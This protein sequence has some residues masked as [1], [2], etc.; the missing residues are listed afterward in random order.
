MFLRSTAL[1]RPAKTL[2]SRRLQHRSY[3]KATSTYLFSA[4]APADHAD[5]PKAPSSP[6]SG[7]GLAAATSY[8]G[9]AAAGG[10][11]SLLSV[12]ISGI[13]MS[14]L[15]GITIKNNGLVE[16]P[17]S[18]KP[19]LTFATKTILQGGIV[20][21]AAKLSFFELLTTGSSGIPVVLGAVS[22]GLI[23]I[24]IMGN[25]AG[26][27]RKMSLLLTAG[28][29][30]CGVTA[31]TALAPAIDAE[32]RDVAVAVANTVAFGTMGM[33][34]YP[35]IFNALCGSSEQ[36]GMCLGVAI[37]DTSQVLGSAMSYRETFDDEMALRVAA[38]TKLT[39]NLGLAV[40]IP[41]L[42]FIHKKEV[43]SGEVKSSEEDTMSGL[44]TFKKYVPP[45]LVAFI[46][47]AGLR[48]TG[49]L[50]MDPET[51]QL[52]Y[53]TVSFVGSDLSK[54]A[55]GTAMAGV[56]LSTDAESLKG[57]GWK[58]FAVGGSGALIVGGTGF[59]IASMIV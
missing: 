24:P 54:Y 29:S 13:P 53:E 12:P 59:T 46:G 22:A 10:L 26:L 40:A 20:C 38:V 27:P 31:I 2:L 1:A 49:D 6:L 47:M 36:V 3:V 14:I 39:R 5:A 8:V 4:N 16:L 52:Y 57:V 50:I 7:I 35:Y 32:K 55:L 34:A 44:A 11:T 45:F 18:V 41:L 58:P 42:T 15:L 9:F 33:L 51:N 43:G 23:S 28:T 19:G 30:I 56:G 17:A 25:L 21:V 48:S 37:H